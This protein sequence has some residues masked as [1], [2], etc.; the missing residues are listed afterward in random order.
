[1]VT[2][3]AETRYFLPIVACAVCLTFAPPSTPA[4][5][6][7]EDIGRGWMQSTWRGTALRGAEDPLEG[8][9]IQ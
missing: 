5:E 4:S 3:T 1:M 6:L 7:S 2:N 9:A 8:I